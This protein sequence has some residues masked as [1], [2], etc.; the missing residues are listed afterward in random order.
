MPRNIPSIRVLEKAGF[1]YEGLAPR[2]L[3]I[4]SVWEDHNLYAA[5]VEDLQGT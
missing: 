1:R 2:Y 3:K 5:T 4:N